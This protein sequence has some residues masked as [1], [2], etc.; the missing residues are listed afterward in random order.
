[1]VIIGEISFYQ[2][3]IPVRSY[4]HRTA[5]KTNFTVFN[6]VVGVIGACKSA[7]VGIQGARTQG[8]AVARFNDEGS[9]KVWSLGID[10]D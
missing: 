2:V 1:M 3:A 9:R 4:C 8:A 7:I 6:I 10:E 5:A